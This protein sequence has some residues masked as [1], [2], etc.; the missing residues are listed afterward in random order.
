MTSANRMPLFVD[1]IQFELTVQD[2][3]THWKVT[4]Y[5]DDKI[6]GTRDLP[7]RVYPQNSVLVYLIRTMIRGQNVNAD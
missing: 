6:L 3:S 5:K 7:I 2:Y 1:G 4:V